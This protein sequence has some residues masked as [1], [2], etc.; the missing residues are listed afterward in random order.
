[1]L[2]YT[3]FAIYY[4]LL[5]PHLDG[6]VN[7]TINT[8]CNPVT[9]KNCYVVITSRKSIF[10]YFPPQLVYTMAT[11]FTPTIPPNLRSNYLYSKKHY[12]VEKG[13]WTPPTFCD[14]ADVSTMVTDFS[15]TV[16]Y[17]VHLYIYIHYV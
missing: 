9:E 17:S 15:L 5:P 16:R 11:I 7:V 1:M 3:Q 13:C 6:N 8:C 14:D 4:R 2:K 10:V 12:G